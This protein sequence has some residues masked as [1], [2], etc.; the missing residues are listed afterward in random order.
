MQVRKPMGRGWLALAPS[1]EQR[2]QLHPHLT[3]TL[4]P[5]PATTALHPAFLPNLHSSPRALIQAMSPSSRTCTQQAGSPSLNSKPV[6]HPCPSCHCPHGALQ[7]CILPKDAQD[8]NSNPGSATTHYLCDSSKP[9]SLSGLQ[10]AHQQN[11][12]SH[13]VSLAGLRSA[14]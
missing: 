11:G 2:P 5:S 7:R 3:P 4:T 14:L 9:S 6:S 13:G 1:T 12:T 10:L 8:L